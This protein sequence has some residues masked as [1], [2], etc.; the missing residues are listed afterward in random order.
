MT[1]R[2]NVFLSGSQDLQIME[3]KSGD[4]SEF[5]MRKWKETVHCGLKTDEFA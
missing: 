1:F 3:V 4:G 2:P 5:C